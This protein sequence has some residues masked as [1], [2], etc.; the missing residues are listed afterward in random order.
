MVTITS[1]EISSGTSI[2][3]EHVEMILR[4]ITDLG[5][6]WSGASGGKF[7]HKS[8]RIESENVKRAYLDYERLSPLLREYFDRYDPQRFESRKTFGVSN[9]F[10]ISTGRDETTIGLISA[11]DVQFMRLAIEQ[12]RLSRP[13]D[14]R[15]HP[16]VGAVVVKDDKV[17]ATAFRGETKAGEHAEFIALEKKLATDVL[18]GATVYTT[19]EPCTTRNHPKMACA[20]RLIRRKVSRV[21]IGMLDPNQSI[22]G[23]GVSR[24]R[25]ANIATDF[26]PSMLMAEVEE[27][28]RDFIKAQEGK[29]VFGEVTRGTNELTE[30]MK[31]LCLKAEKHIRLLIH[32]TGSDH[33]LTDE[34]ADTIAEYI[35]NREI[36]GRPVRFWPIIVV[37][38]EVAYDD[39]RSLL[40]ALDR[41][42]AIYEWYGVTDF[43]SPRFL[44]SSSS[45][46]IDAL[47]I[48]HSY[49]LLSIMTASAAKK[50]QISVTFEQHPKLI[51]E[52]I[53]W[54]DH[55]VGSQTIS[56]FDFRLSLMDPSEVF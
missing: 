32:A 31:T 8:I 17:L 22:T 55:V 42:T 9:P 25:E 43:T 15:I 45:L 48:D 4:L 35:R 36:P 16:L 20:E 28:N 14:K 11:S 27:I 38:N 29:V 41:R 6:F 13:E 56:L 19:L 3:E 51:A 33:K 1:E 18:T 2:N 39:R 24:L 40:E 37:D 12:A 46:N 26:F 52:L 5:D 34:F 7:G 23:K 47:I 54:F 44:P 49:A 10:S 30:L 21:V 53:D 50:A